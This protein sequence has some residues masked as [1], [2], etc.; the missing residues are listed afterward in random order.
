MVP[1]AADARLALGDPSRDLVIVVPERDASPVTQRLAAMLHR[2]A[3]ILGV[4]L[5]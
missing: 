1:F 4:S 3:R 2:P 5:P